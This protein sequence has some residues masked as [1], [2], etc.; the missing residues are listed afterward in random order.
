MAFI[1]KHSFKIA[2]LALCAAMAVYLLLSMKSDVE[3]LKDFGPAPS[4]ELSDLEGNKVTLEDTN[5]KVRLYYFYFSYCPDVCPPTTA[6]LAQVQDEMIRQGRFG[7]DVMITSIT[8]DP[9]RDTPERIKEFAD[10]FGVDYAGWNWLRGDEQYTH[11]V[12][13]KFGLSVIKADGNYSHTNI[14]FLV[15]QEGKIRKYL[16]A[17]EDLTTEQIIQDVESLL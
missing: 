11:E 10:Q 14:I 15:D 9:E 1:R 4:F 16:M 2:V 6:Q 12:A 5:G 7:K 17:N 13:Q 8:I 3:P